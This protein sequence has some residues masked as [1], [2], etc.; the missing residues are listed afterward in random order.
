MCTK[1]LN[2]CDE[3]K[4]RTECSVGTY[5][6]VVIATSSKGTYR[7]C[8][9]MFFKISLLTADSVWG[10]LSIRQTEKSAFRHKHLSDLPGGIHTVEWRIGGR[11][12][13][14]EL[15]SWLL[16]YFISL[17]KEPNQTQVVEFWVYI[18]KISL[19]IWHM[20][21][22]GMLFLYFQIFLHLL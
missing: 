12:G 1:L 19:S 2:G 20:F 22:L 3:G 13:E 11:R 5:C 16:V 14:I 10:K 9:W 4:E 18:H 17:H 6:I 15:V 8:L 21:L 7:R